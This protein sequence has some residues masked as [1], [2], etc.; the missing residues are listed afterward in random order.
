MTFCTDP[1]SDPDPGIF[2][3]DLQ[4]TTR[5]KNFLNFFAYYF[6]KLHLHHFKEEVTKQYRRY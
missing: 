2:V 3:S 4:M 1:D 6:L 5:K